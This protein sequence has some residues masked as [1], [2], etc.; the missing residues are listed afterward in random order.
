[1]TTVSFSQQVQKSRE[2]HLIKSDSTAGAIRAQG[3]DRRT[4]GGNN[5]E[6]A[7][8]QL[9]AAVEGDGRDDCRAEAPTLLRLLV[10]LHYNRP[11]SVMA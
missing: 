5:W 9:L 2:I 3:M 7:R 8:S 4:S 11:P 1:M 6:T 10:I